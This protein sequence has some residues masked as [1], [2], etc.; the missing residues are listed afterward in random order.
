MDSRIIEIIEELNINI[1]RGYDEDQ[2]VDCQNFY[3]D[4]FGYHYV[5]YK[6]NSILLLKGVY[7]DFIRI[8]KG[9]KFL[10]ESEFTKLSEFLS[11]IEKKIGKT[12]SAKVVKGERELIELKLVDSFEKLSIRDRL[13]VNNPLTKV[14]YSISKDGNADYNNLYF[15][16]IFKDIFPNTVTTLTASFLNSIPEVLSVIFSHANFRVYSPSLKLLSGKVYGSFSTYNMAFESLNSTDSLLKLNYSQF[17]YLKDKKRRLKTPK[18]SIL[19]ISEDEVREFI[20]EAEEKVAGIDENYIFEPDFL[21]YISILFLASQMV[22]LNFIE[23]FMKIYDEVENLDN[24][25]RL[26]YKTREESL[27]FSKGEIAVPESFDLQS[28]IL[29]M[30][31]FCGEKPLSINEEV[32]K[33]SK[34]NIFKRKR[35]EGIVTEIH[36][37]LRLRDELSLASVKVF[38][39]VKN[40]I[41]NLSNKLLNE[42]KIK[43]NDT[44]YYLEYNDLK[45]ILNDNYYGNIQFTYFFKKWQTERYKMQI[46]P[47]EI[48]EKDIPDVENI[49]KGI[50]NK[51][52]NQKEFDILSFFHKDDLCGDLTNFQIYENLTFLKYN[53]KKPI[54]TDNI[55]L[56]SYAMEYAAINDIPV[57]S[58]IRY[59]ELILNGRKFK[60]NKSKLSIINGERY[61]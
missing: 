34:L 29:K 58:G 26:I 35:L 10:T 54:I 27:F 50:I 40:V 45:N 38:S 52:L 6:E 15:S 14:E 42:S 60:I 46:L 19:E 43:H 31:I 13:Y 25:L 11:D 9:E 17:R 7:K 20:R 51:L 4:N 37:T 5:K 18:I 22:F 53:S 61:D 23:Q 28:D 39:K 1:V 49:V 48:F 32:K 41:N 2:V 33:Y 57:Y 59:P 56:L 30:S 36:K 3:F 55:S 21:E 12:F 44:I 16:S 47:Y 8:I 24:A